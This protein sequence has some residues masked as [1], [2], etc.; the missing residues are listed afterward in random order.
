MPTSVAAT[1]LDSF[2]GI[3][4]R[5]EGITMD[6][7]VDIGGYALDAVG[8]LWLIAVTGMFASAIC[9]S[10]R[11]K[12]AEG[13]EKPGGPGL[14]VAGIASLVTP[15]LLFVHGF[16]TIAG[17]EDLEITPDILMDLI[18]ARQVVVIAMFGFLAGVAILGS[19]IG[20]IIRAAAPGLGR[21][22]NI[23]AVPLALATLALTIFVTYKAAI[24]VFT[25]AAA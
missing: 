18:L 4:D 15:I 24:T 21:M 3:A 25:L 13:E 6:S 7:N 5:F 11:P 20:W 1:A 10:A 23:A 14:L 2:P 8:P 12:P 16:W 9:E 22:L 19:I 17:F